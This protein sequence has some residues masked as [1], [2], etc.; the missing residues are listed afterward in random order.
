MFTREQLEGILVAIARPQIAIAQNV[1]HSTGYKIKL[2]VEIR[3]MNREF[4][5]LLQESL[6]E[7]GIDSYLKEIEKKSRPYP[8]LRI[9]NADNLINLFQLIPNYVPQHCDN[10]DSFLEAVTLFSNKHHLTQK[11]LNRMLEIKGLL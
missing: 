5:V 4:L 2:S 6:K 10:F 9:T 7:C 11:G 8:V 1:R 3:A